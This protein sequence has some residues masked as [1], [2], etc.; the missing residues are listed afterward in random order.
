M[1]RVNNAMRKLTRNIDKLFVEGADIAN[2]DREIHRRI[3]L[4][5]Y[6]PSMLNHEKFPNA[7]SIAVNDRICHAVPHSYILR[8]GDIVT[9]DLCLYN[10]IHSDWAHTFIIGGKT[11]KKRKNLVKATQ[12]CMNKAIAF[13]APG[14]Y[15]EEI[16]DIISAVAA[17]YNCRVIKNLGGHGIGTE[18]HMMPYISNERKMPNTTLMKVG[19]VIT[20]EPL[21]TTA[22]TGDTRLHKD[23]FTIMTLDGSPAAHFERTLIITPTGHRVLN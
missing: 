7:T 4:T 15:Y 16:G 23:G 20:I 3:K 17:K 1:Y 21:L 5:N 18:L 22:K 14:R 11:T 19:D 6:K 10:K 2:I 12:E 13:C 8:R 9:L